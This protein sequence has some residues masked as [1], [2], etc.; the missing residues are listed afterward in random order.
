MNFNILRTVPLMVVT[1]HSSP[2][3]PTEEPRAGG[4]VE[5]MEILDLPPVT[6]FTGDS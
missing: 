6:T 5:R 1:A 2:S 3:L 4:R